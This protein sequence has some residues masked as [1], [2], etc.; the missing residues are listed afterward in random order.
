LACFVGPRYF[1]V[2]AIRHGD[3]LEDDILDGGCARFLLQPQ[4]GALPTTRYA[5]TNETDDTMFR[6]FA[7]LRPARFPW[8]PRL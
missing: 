7:N 3:I 5:D 1:G 4:K 8:A 2:Q 6:Y